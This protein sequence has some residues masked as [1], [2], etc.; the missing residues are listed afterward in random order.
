MERR[1]RHGQVNDDEIR[2]NFHFD[3]QDD[4]VTITTSRGDRGELRMTLPKA[5]SVSIRVPGWAVDSVHIEVDGE[6]VTLQI[7][8]GFACIDTTT[9]N[10]II[11]VSYDLPERMTEETMPVSGH[12]YRLVWR[13]DEIVGI[14]PWEQSALYPAMKK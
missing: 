14:D 7:R 10:T 2:V 1:T 9:P 5:H 13:G 3:Y 6:S 4:G 12:T 8:D 11:N